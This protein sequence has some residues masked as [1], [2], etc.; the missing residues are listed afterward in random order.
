MM[1]LD[2]SAIYTFSPGTYNL[3]PVLYQ[4]S[5][6]TLS[7]GASIPNIFTVYRLC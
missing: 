1:S 7:V 3:T 4:T 6:S 5:G 2:K